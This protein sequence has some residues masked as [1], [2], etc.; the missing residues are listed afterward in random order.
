M[1]YNSILETIGNTPLVRLNRVVPKN[2]KPSVYAKLERFNPMGS[3]KDRPALA[4]I[5]DAEK[6]GVLRPG[7]TIVEA[8]SGNTGL[9]LAMI[10]AVKGYK[11]RL[12]IEHIDVLDSTIFA[13]EA[14]GAELHFVDSFEEAVAYAERQGS[15]N[16][17]VYVPHQF[18]NV[19]NPA[20]HQRTTA[21][22]IL[23]DLDGKISCFVASFG[24]GGTFTGVGSVLKEF[25][26]AIRLIL[27]EPDTVPLFSGGK[28]ACSEIHGVGPTFKS[29][30]FREELIDDILQVNAHQAHKMMKRLAS[31]EGMI[32]GPSSGALAHAACLVANKY[33]YQDASIVTVFPDMG[34]RYFNERLFEDQDTEPLTQPYAV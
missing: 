9:G 34:D 25:N 22:E 14:L 33:N 7:M 19:S 13:A 24:S 30:F 8:T 6:R 23:G 4:M 31:E 32:V 12:I 5:E 11:I 17:D 2:L 16:S 21:K 20:V 15:E 1:L 29:S 18:K 28:I 10:A 26:P 3:V 27:V